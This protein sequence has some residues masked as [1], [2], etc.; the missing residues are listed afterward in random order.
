MKNLKSEERRRESFRGDRVSDL[1]SERGFHM[2]LWSK[3][4]VAIGGGKE[5]EEEEEEEE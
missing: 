2:G 5:E 1:E 3:W 4:T